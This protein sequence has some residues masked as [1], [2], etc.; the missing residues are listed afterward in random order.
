METTA[1]TLASLVTDVTSVFTAAIGWLGTVAQ[2]VGS[3]PLLLM[4]CI[5]GFGGIA[6]SWFRR[7]LN[8]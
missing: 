4:G 7:L 6:I 1:M 8:V 3:N 2:T 5:L